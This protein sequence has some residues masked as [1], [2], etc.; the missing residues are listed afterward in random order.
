VKATTQKQPVKCCSCA[1]QRKLVCRLD[2]ELGNEAKRLYICSRCRRQAEG[3]LYGPKT[4]YYLFTFAPRIAGTKAPQQRPV[5]L[6][7]SNLES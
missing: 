3:S 2:A 6:F 5:A 4:V 7:V 1:A